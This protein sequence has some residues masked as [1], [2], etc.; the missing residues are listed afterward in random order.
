[1][2]KEIQLGEIQFKELIKKSLCDVNFGNYGKA[3]EKVASK[4]I[5][6]EKNIV[7]GV[8]IGIETDCSYTPIAGNGCYIWLL[9]YASNIPNFDVYDLI[10]LF[11]NG[12]FFFG[13][14]ENEDGDG[15]GDYIRKYDYIWFD[16]EDISKSSIFSYY[17]ENY[18]KNMEEVYSGDEGHVYVVRLKK[19]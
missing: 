18:G 12:V 10:R 19:Q 3:V 16:L 2:T 17:K 9:E 11:T 4:V 14:K 6:N 15:D 13:I 7:A 5:V 8:I 1:M